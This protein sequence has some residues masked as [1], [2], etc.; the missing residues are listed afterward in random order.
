MPKTRA[1]NTIRLKVFNVAWQKCD[2]PYNPI[3]LHSLV[4]TTTS[5]ES[6]REIMEKV[7][8]DVK[9]YTIE[10]VAVLDIPI[11]IQVVL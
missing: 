4:V 1:P 3:S 10:V 7:Y 9:E 8:S 11:N 6:V 5:K 2:S